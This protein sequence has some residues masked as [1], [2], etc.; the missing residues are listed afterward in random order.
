M[1]EIQVLIQQRGLAPQFLS[2][3]LIKQISWDNQWI[4]YDDADT[5]SLKT[6]WADQNC[7]GGTVYWSVDMVGVGTLVLSILALLLRIDMLNSGDTPISPSTDGSCSPTTHCLYSSAGPCCSAYG[8]CGSD[9]A[10]CSINNGCRVVSGNCNTVS[11]DGSCGVGK[12]CTGSGL[13]D[14]CSSKGWCGTGDEWC[15]AGCQS[16]FGVCH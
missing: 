3:K 11:I 15:G 12:T 9:A 4:G 2:D 1:R 5:I 10:H 8:Y 14:C 16:S 7:L 6:S 13:G